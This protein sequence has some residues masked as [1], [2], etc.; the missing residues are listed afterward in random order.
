MIGIVCFARQEQRDGSGGRLWLE[1]AGKE[2][3]RLARHRFLIGVGNILGDRGKI[4]DAVVFAVV[5]GV[6]VIG[7]VVI[8]VVVIGV[9]DRIV[10]VLMTLLRDAERCCSFFDHGIS[11]GDR[12]SEQA[13]A[14][15]LEERT[16]LGTELLGELGTPTINDSLIIDRVVDI[17]VDDIGSDVGCRGARRCPSRISRLTKASEQRGRL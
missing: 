16:D 7:V 4:L 17:S 6:V 14:G 1:G 13:E 2:D 5:I 15:G 12:L 9:D 3:G 8:G 10:G 11:V